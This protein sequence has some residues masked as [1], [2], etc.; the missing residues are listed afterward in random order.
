M[1][2]LRRHNGAKFF[3]KNNSYFYARFQKI[4]NGSTFITIQ[5]CGMKTNK[6]KKEYIFSRNFSFIPL[7]V[8]VG[9][10]QGNGGIKTN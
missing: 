9:H 7:S 1:T 5:N 2:H 6:G 3:G 10:F 4:G 8:R